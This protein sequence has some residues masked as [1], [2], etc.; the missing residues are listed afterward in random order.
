MIDALTHPTASYPQP[1]ASL[2]VLLMDRWAF[3]EVSPDLRLEAQI[4]EP[5][6]WYDSSAPANGWVGRKSLYSARWCDPVNR[7]MEA[8]RCCGEEE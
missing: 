7:Q 3:A 4:A 2:A 1:A 5:I 8:P 6:I